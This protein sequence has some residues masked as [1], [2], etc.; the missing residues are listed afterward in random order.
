MWPL[1]GVTGAEVDLAARTVTVR[2]QPSAGP[3]SLRQAIEEQGYAV[4]AA[5]SAPGQP[6]RKRDQRTQMTTAAVTRAAPAGSAELQLDAEGMTCGSCASRNERVTGRQTGVESASVNFAG[7]RHLQ[8][9]PVMG[10]PRPGLKFIKQ[11]ERRLTRRPML[12][13]CRAR[14]VAGAHFPA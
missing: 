1:P 6:A 10:A 11:N 14:P 5:G 13:G 4:P 9:C 12:T 7:Y 2:Y 8:R 3:E